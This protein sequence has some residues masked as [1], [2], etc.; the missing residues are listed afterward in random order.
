MSSQKMKN[1]IKQSHQQLEK[2][3]EAIEAIPEE[4][5]SFYREDYVQEVEDEELQARPED[6]LTCKKCQK[7]LSDD[8]KVINARFVNE[9][10]AAFRDISNFPTCF[11]CNLDNIETNV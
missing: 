9:A 8:E 10:M 11:M 1:M 3:Q 4:T 6:F 7:D 5:Q 2:Q